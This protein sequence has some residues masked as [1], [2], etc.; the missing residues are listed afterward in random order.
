MNIGRPLALASLAL[1]SALGG[2][3]ARA[4]AGVTV[5]IR[6]FGAIPNDGKNDA[7]ALRAA[8]AAC[9]A[10]GA[11][12]L[13]FP[14]GQ[15]LL[16]DAK[17]IDLQNVAMSGIYGDGLQAMIF[18]PHYQYVIGLDFK[19]IK[20]LT[21]E[22]ANAELLCDGWMEPVSLVE[23][24]NLVINGLSIDY[25]RPPN[26]IGRII[27]VSNGN[28]DVKFIER[29]P[30][31]DGM[32]FLRTML[33][34][35]DEKRFVGNCSVPKG[36][37]IAPQVLRFT[38]ASGPFKV[39]RV[40]WAL[41]GFHFRPAILLYMAKN[42]TLNDVSIYAQPGMGI[43]GHL[44]ENIFLNRLRIVPKD[45]TRYCSSNTDATHFASCYGTLEFDHCDF[46]GQGDDAT[47]VHNYYQSVIARNGSNGCTIGVTGSFDL[48]SQ[49]ADVPR[50]GDSLAIVNSQTLEEIGYITV[51]KVVGVDAD[52]H[53]SIEYGG[54]LP[55]DMGTRYLANVSALPRFV[56]RNCKVGSH[57]ARSVLCKTRKVLIEGNTFYGSTGTAIHLGAEGDWKEGAA[58][59]DVVIRNNTFTLSGGGDGTIDGASVIAIH[60]NAP[61]T[62]VAGLHQRILIENNT[63]IR[64]ASQYAITVKGAEDVTIRN[65]TL[66]QAMD[67][68][69]ALVVGASRRVAA[70]GNAGMKDYFSN[71][72]TPRLPEVITPTAIASPS[73][74]DVA[75]APVVRRELYSLS[76][77]LLS[78]YKQSGRPG[79][80]LV[81]LVHGNGRSDTRVIWIR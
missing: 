50:A 56:F 75:G 42:T 45:S 44:S 74:A 13:V 34:D 48:H 81:R 36:K 37:L 80:Y 46:A 54:A 2:A 6:D 58:S 61:N 57:R 22:A 39:G 71:D 53:V 11:G 26:S 16:A 72:G 49:K 8:V 60:V 68:G 17:A 30:V 3:C 21:I 31:T 41:H 4:H 20:N 15:Y 19:G 59:R 67:P 70:Y 33:W 73:R 77:K 9:R 62:G 25:K 66:T 7:D 24:E 32:G 51:A 43:V 10:N 1:L 79:L 29:C 78:G 27:D 52:N 12:T 28:V 76:G 5:N 23:T 18:N 35:D 63:I 65:N 69:Q 64:P 47:N 40:L 55:A 38:G 14:P